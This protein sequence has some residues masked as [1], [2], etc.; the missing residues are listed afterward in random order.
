MHWRNWQEVHWIVAHL[1][2]ASCLS[3]AEDSTI[4]PTLE[5][6]SVA[7]FRSASIVLGLPPGVLHK[8]FRSG[9]AF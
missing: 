9:L 5:C 3:N 2:A 6:F 7:R 1:G 4:S 8:E